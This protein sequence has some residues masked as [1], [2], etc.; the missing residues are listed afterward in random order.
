[1]KN[2]DWQN[3][4]ALFRGAVAPMKRMNDNL[5]EYFSTNPAWKIRAN[6][7]SGIRLIFDTDAV[8][9]E[10]IAAFGDAARQIFTTDVEVDGKLTTFD[11]TGPHTLDLATG[12][13]RVVIYPPHLAVLND[14]QIKVNQSAM[15]EAVTENRPKLLICADSIMQ[16]MTCSS[17]ARASVVLAANALDMDLHNTSVGGAVMKELTARETLKLSSR[18]QDIIVLALGCN[19]AAQGTDPELFRQ[20]TAGAMKLL[21]EFPGKALVITP[22]PALT[23]DAEKLEFYRQ[24]IRDEKQKYPRIALLEGTS[25]YPAE[26]ELFVDGVHPNDEGMQI[27]AQAIVKAIQTD[28]LSN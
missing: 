15:V 4:F 7:P 26:A 12:K 16:G 11:G 3:N 25:F 5:L 10:I 1:M 20:E 8:K 22:I 19:N 2:I 6:C 23:V 28:V 9:L 27:Y 24:I 14:F 21:A 17:P 13:K 18:T